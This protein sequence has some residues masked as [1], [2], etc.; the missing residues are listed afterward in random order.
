[1]DTNPNIDH[2]GSANKGKVLAGI[3]LLCIGASWL[4]KEFDFFFFPHWLLSWPMWLIVGG[5]YLGG[6]N[7]FRNSSWVFAVAIGAVFLLGEAIPGLDA[8]AIVWPGMLITFG[9]WMIVRRN[10]TTHWDKKSWKNKWESS[11]YDFNVKQPISAEP[12]ADFNDATDTNTAGT[13][14]QPFYSGDEHLEAISI[15]GSVKK[16]IYSKNFQGGE[17]V[18]VFGGAEIDLTQADII[19]RVYIEV[20]QVF[21]GVKM[22]VPSHWTVVSDV[23]AVFAGFDDKRVRTAVPQDANKVLV[24]KGTSIFAGVDVRSY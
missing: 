11:K 2:Q 18:N 13:P 8:G 1:M 23:A 10:Q 15:F 20:T 19:G 12:I 4:L 6:K 16:T 22:I 14:S 17:V 9:I 21:G 24:I 3:I 5:L 7:N